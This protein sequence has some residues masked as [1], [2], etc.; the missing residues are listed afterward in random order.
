MEQLSETVV[1]QS[2]EQSPPKRPVPPQFV[3]KNF[4]PGVS[5]NP[6]GR[7]SPRLRLAAEIE[8][9]VADFR[10]VHG[11]APNRT[12]RSRIKRAADFGIQAER[13]ISV[14]D[15]VKASNASERILK[16]LG[17]DKPVQSRQTAVPLPTGYDR[18]SR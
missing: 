15:R 3:G 12:E 7:A 11:R 8:V 9:L 16:K 14:E 4:Q 1:K 5:G 2:S 13:S 6:A 10:S 17:L 18:E